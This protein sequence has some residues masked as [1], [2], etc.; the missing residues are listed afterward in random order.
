MHMHIRK[1]HNGAGM[2]SQLIANG[3][4]GI[5][6]MAQRYPHGTDSFRL[7]QRE[8]AAGT[9]VGPRAIGP[10]VDLPY[11]VSIPTLADVP[12]VIDSLQAAGM[13]FLKVH[14]KIRSDRQRQIF[15]ATLRE[16][17]RVGLP[18]VG[19]VPARGVTE[20]EAADSGMRSVEHINSNHTCWHAVVYADGDSAAID[21]ACRQ[22]VQAYLRNGT[23]FTPT[24]QI[25]LRKQAGKPDARR[26]M[27]NAVRELHRLGITKFLAGSDEMY[28]GG[29][30]LLRELVFLN[31][32]G[33]TPVEALQAATLNPA[34]FLAATDSLGTVAPGKLADLV[35]LDQN[36]LADLLNILTIRAVVANGRY[37]DR[38]ALDA[39]DPEGVQRIRA[40]LAQPRAAIPGSP[41]P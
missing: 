27:F 22:T 38:A 18:V 3:V 37:F 26:W 2:Y 6:E 41:T 5:R 39:L 13:V 11:N 12:R 20:M 8:V 10:S 24:L 17:R 15:W 34:T 16:A 35:L 40:F 30:P 25:H 14:D 32:A 1:A 31:A 28:C 4:T 9:R 29:F 23:W 21:Q 33:L 7:W 36:P 19:H